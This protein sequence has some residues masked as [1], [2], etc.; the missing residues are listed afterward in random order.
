M[1]STTTVLAGATLALVTTIALSS[2]SAQNGA[3]G[4][5]NDG[6]FTKAQAD[7]A[8]AQFTKM[9][10]DCHAFA[11]DQR[12]K[13]GDVVLGGPVFLKAWDGR[14]LD[15]MVTTIVMTMPSDGS[16]EV[17]EPEG[18]DLVAY[19]LQQNGYPAGPA[20]LT[21]ETAAGVVVRPKK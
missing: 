10:A 2:V 16:G 21:K 20:P 17:T 7:R 3:K 19:I 1:T 9:C 8:N 14:T 13:P 18:L 15:E 5:S 6:V 12:K 4:T 11:V